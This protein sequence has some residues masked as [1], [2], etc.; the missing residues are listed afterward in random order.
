MYEVRLKV[1]QEAGS[2]VLCHPRGPKAPIVVGGVYTETLHAIVQDRA[3]M[4]ATAPQETD[5]LS[6][7]QFSD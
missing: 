3:S 5:M 2:L 7:W 4:G 6:I 1:A